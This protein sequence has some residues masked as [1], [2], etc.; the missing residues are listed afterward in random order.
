MISTCF[1][2]KIVG[3][4]KPLDLAVTSYLIVRHER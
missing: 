3:V 4:K 2:K 1:S